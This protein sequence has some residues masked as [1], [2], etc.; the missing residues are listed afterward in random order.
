MWQTWLTEIGLGIAWLFAQPVL[1]IA[2]LFSFLIG[3][4]RIKQDRKQFGHRVFP[5]HAEW[6]GTWLLGLVLGIILSAGFVLTG[7]VV[8]WEWLALWTAVFIVMFLTGQVALLSPAY[9]LGLSIVIIWL[10]ER[11]DV[12][13]WNEA[14]TDRLYQVS[15]EDMVYLLLALLLVEAIFIVMTKR[16]QTFPRLYAGDRGKDVGAHRVSRL[17]LVPLLIPLPGGPLSLVDSFSWWPVFATESIGMQFVMFP[18]VVGFAQTFRGVFSDQGAKRIGL[19]LMLLVVV[20]T[21]VWV[22]L[23]T[24]PY[25]LVSVVASAIVLRAVISLVV[26][27]FDRERRPVFRPESEGITIVGVVPG[28]PASDLD[29]QIGEKIE[30]VHDVPVRNEYEF[31]D[32][33]SENRAYCKLNVR[34]LNGETKFV[35]RSI[36]EGED[37]QLGFIFVK[38]TPRFSLQSSETLSR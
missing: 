13:V 11:F 3:W 19:S 2:I 33:M 27:F 38:E 20:L 5:L 4:S 29:V 14:V 6:R 15:L 28:S 17:M 30:R 18:Y 12:V 24:L 35:Q 25:V 10:L 21:A 8:T 1:Y 9:T 23:A 22:P 31:F 26:R 7:M 36:Y 32:V 16:S 34:D 37:H